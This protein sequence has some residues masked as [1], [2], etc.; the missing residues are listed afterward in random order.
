MSSTTTIVA[1]YDDDDDRRL[2]EGPGEPVSLAELKTYAPFR[3]FNAGQ[4]KRAEGG[5]WLRRYA[6][7]EYICRQGDFGSTAFYIVD[8]EVR[9]ELRSAA[10]APMPPSTNKSSLFD[11]LFGRSR[12]IGAGGRSRSTP[13]ATSTASPARS[14]SARTT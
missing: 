13:P 9:V 11:R 10:E 14:C 2:G 3:H 4:L 1:R 8:G 6:A 5:V 7:G 12:P